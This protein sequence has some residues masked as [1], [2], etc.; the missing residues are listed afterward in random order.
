MARMRLP[1]KPSHTPARTGVLRSRRA[2]S[3]PVA[4]VSAAVCSPTTI[5]SSFMML[6]GEKKCSPS[7]SAGPRVAEA[8]RFTS[9]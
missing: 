1:M 4:T 9:R 8:M 5:S 3:N 7:T 2:S 6:A